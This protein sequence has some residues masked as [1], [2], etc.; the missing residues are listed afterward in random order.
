MSKSYSHLLGVINNNNKK[1]QKTMVTIKG[2]TDEAKLKAWCHSYYAK[3]KKS[4][5]TDVLFDE[6][7][8]QFTDYSKGTL[9]AAMRKVWDEI[10]V[11]AGGKQA[12][13]SNKKRKAVPSIGSDDLIAMARSGARL[14]DDESEDDDEYGT[15]RY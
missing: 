11:V 3:N 10:G 7:G 5:F 15:Y 1:K 14:K 9:Q 4:C 13:K 8:H 6:T 2:T 12:A